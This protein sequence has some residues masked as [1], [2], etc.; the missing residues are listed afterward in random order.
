MC[1]FC[2][3]FWLVIVI[4]SS[5]YHHFP[6]LSLKTLTEKGTHGEADRWHAGNT[7]EDGA[8]VSSRSAGECLWHHSIA[9]IIS[10]SH[11]ILLQ[12]G[13]CHFLIHVFSCQLHMQ[14]AHSHTGPWNTTDFWF[15]FGVIFIILALGSRMFYVSVQVVWSRP[16][17]F[18]V[19][20][21]TNLQF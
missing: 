6:N 18:Q 13:L 11:A 10:R 21:K 2:D 19:C 8:W 1:N 15:S 9:Q 16:I 3:R 20:F 12:R 7:R 17:L 5:I 4:G 14:E